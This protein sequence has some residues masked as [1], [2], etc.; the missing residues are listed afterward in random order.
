MTGAVTGRRKDEHLDVCVTEQVEPA[1]RTT[2]LECVDLVHCAMPEL[3]V[4]DIDLGANL[5]GRPLRAPLVIT[6]MTGGTPRSAQVNRGLASAAQQ[7]GVA[8]GVGSQRAMAEDAS[9]AR[10][11]RVRDVAPSIPLLGNI[12]LRQADQ[13][14]ADGVARLREA[15]DADGMALHLNAAQ[16]L[17]QPEGDR[18][19]RGGY[20]LLE[21]LVR[22]L[23]GAVLVKETGCG[24]APAVARRLVD[25]G[26]AVIDV[27]GA[28]GTSWVRVEQLRTPDAVTPVADD[29]ATWGI[30]TAAATIACRDVLGDGVTLIASGGI[31]TGLDA[32]RALAL[33]ADL[34][35]TAL[36]LLR[37][38]DVGGTP[39]AV[40]ATHRLIDNLR[41]VILLTG[42][43]AASE[44]RHT[45]KIVHGPL[46]RWRSA[47]VASCGPREP[48][49]TEPPREG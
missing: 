27:S 3:H 7:A 28:G 40:D 21:R 43:G 49:A 23:D 37:A 1:G 36:P 16:E 42:S 6:G 9:R 47:L 38:W 26:V 34:A 8:F 41:H 30:P 18:D 14:G 10:F 17:T 24:I 2:L 46:A 25:C 11:Y 4:A 39:A 13:L 5:F 19:F 15:I 32:A 33:G 45:P 31:R 44:L 20:A 29:M 48:I 35:G 22:R 12:G